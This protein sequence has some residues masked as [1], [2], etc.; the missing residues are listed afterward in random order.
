M[1]CSRLKLGKVRSNRIRDGGRRDGCSA[2]D[3]RGRPSVRRRGAWRRPSL[4]QEKSW[5]GGR[6]CNLKPFEAI[7]RVRPPPGRGAAR[8]P[9]ASLAW[10]AA[11]SLVKRRQRMLKPCVS[12]DIT[13]PLRPSVWVDRGGV[14]ESAN[15]EVLPARPGSW[16]WAKAWDGSP[17]N[18]RDPVRVH[19]RNRPDQGTPADQLFQAWRTSST[20][21]RSAS[22]STNNGGARGARNRS[23]KG[24]GLRG[25]EVVAP[26]YDL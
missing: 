13:Y 25:R 23:H 1:A 26:S 15:G 17:G 21:V 19:G 11:T 12:L 9:E 3:R 7:Q 18:L 5:K 24:A 16:S 2:R 8:Q 14:D 6:L 10:A 20:S 22:A 4:R